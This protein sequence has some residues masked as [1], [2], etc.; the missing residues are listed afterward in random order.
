MNDGSPL[1]PNCV[2]VQR[3]LERAG[4]H[5]IVRE[6]S[7]STRSAAEA[8]RALGVEVAQIAKSIVFVAGT[9]PVL[10]VLS[11]ANRASLPK[12]KG[13]VSS[14]IRQPSAAEVKEMVGFP[15]GGVP[16]L[17]HAVRV[18]T[19]LDHD[20]L[21]FPIIWAAAGTPRSVFACTPQELAR[22]IGSGF[23]DLKED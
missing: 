9:L 5:I 2:V 21:Q 8:A 20:L 10:A 22:A 17:G 6:L 18:I 14:D 23:V 7:D 4:I 1:H 19:L 15:A 16:P 11:G 12:I 13:L 3:A